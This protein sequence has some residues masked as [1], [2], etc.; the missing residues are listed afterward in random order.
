ME[1]GNRRGLIS[2]VLSASLTMALINDLH[3]PKVPPVRI[4]M[5]MIIC[6]AA[7]AFERLH[8]K[9]RQGKD[10]IGSIHV[11]VQSEQL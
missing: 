6:R 1:S 4:A 10:A 7:A 8:G 5:A 3:P 11:P 2:T 9:T